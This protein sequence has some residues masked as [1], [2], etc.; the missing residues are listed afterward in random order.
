[1]IRATLDTSVLVSALNFG[2]IL[3]RVLQALDSE[4]FLLCISPS[5]IE[6][7]KRVLT[8]RFE[9][10][11]DDLEAL[12]QIVSQAEIVEPARVVHA[13]RDPDDDHVLACALEAKA[14]VIVSGDKDLL[15]IGQFESIP[16]LT[17]RQF[18][19]RLASTEMDQ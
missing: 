3:E 11:Q 2:G 14:D 17:V 15:D 16:I 19:D 12:D 5:I 18:L 10:S 6:E 4:S 13:S 1:M 9:W 7:T 8:A